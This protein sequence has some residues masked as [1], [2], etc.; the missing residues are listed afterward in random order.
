MILV[1]TTTIAYKCDGTELSWL[2]NLQDYPDVKYFASLQIDSRGLE[3]FAKLITRLGEIDGDWWQ[4][5]YDDGSSHITGNNRVQR[6]CAGRNM[7]SDY[8]VRPNAESY[9]PFEWILFVD[10]DM[11]IP[12]DSIKKLLEI[13]WPIV[14]GE[15]PPYALSGP[16]VERHQARIW[17]E[18][19]AVWPKEGWKQPFGFPVQQHWNTAGFL[20]VHRSLF[21]R[22]RWRVDPDAGMTDDPAYAWDALQMG[23]PT[24]VRKDLIGQ[25]ASMAGVGDND[26]KIYR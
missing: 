1:A 21:R 25:H 20:M 19:G 23:W 3:P 5:S 7:I 11:E 14:G 8:G 16:E 9:E 12:S 4:F 15:V 26:R 6:I 17:L 13:N 24:L 10:S 2:K 22:L 18:D